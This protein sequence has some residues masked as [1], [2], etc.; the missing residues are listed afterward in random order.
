MSI[1]EQ[2]Y[3]QHLDPNTSRTSPSGSAIL[4]LSNFEPP[5][6]NSSSSTISPNDQFYPF[7]ASDPISSL[8]NLPSIPD[9]NSKSSDIHTP[10]IQPPTPTPTLPT[11]SSKLSKLASSRASTLSS[12]SSKSSRSSGTAVTGSIKTFPALR[13]SAQSERPPTSVAASPKSVASSKELPPLPPHSEVSAPSSTSSLVRRAI[14]TALQLEDMDRDV[15]P[16]MRAYT[17]LS[18]AE[19]DDRSKTPTPSDPKPGSPLKVAPTVDVATSPQR[20][21]SKLAQRKAESTVS[22]RSPVD[23]PSPSQSTT[24]SRPLSKLALLAQ[25]KVD[26]SRVPKLPKT[27]TEYLTPIANGPSVTTAI[28]TSYQSLYSL[29]DPAKSSI[30]PKLNVVPLNSPI[31]SPTDQK[32]SK[33]AMKIKRA[34][35]KPF[36]PGFPTEEE[37]TTPPLSPLFMPNTSQARASPSAF[38][39]IL[40]HDPISRQDKS[41]EKDSKRKKKEHGQ[42]KEKDNAFATPS[43]TSLDSHPHRTRKHKH[44]S[45]SPAEGDSSS[46]PFTFD[47]PSPDDVVLNAR[48]G[49]ALGQKS[50]SSASRV[51][52]GTGKS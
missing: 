49:T 43:E 50:S 34:S 21:L 7:T 40:I 41:K 24:S 30:I 9:L 13:P 17:P 14:Q 5:P 37:V 16:K 6:S 28:T 25:Q 23:L 12:A 47:G 44:P 35:E 3:Y 10:V 22:S 45:K 48:K 8:D 19:D 32:A 11:K 38:A 46:R 26:A 20:P 18:F 4:H 27:T 33:L 31:T 42:K 52:A 2:E 51:S 15:T 39:S 36:S 29:T 1:N